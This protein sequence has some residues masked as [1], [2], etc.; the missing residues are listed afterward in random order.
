M[1]SGKINIEGIHIDSIVFWK[2]NP[3]IAYS[4]LPC[5]ATEKDLVNF[6]FSEQDAIHI[7]LSMT[8]SGFSPIEPLWGFRNYAGE[9]ECEGGRRIAAMKALLNPDMIEDSITRERLL[10][11][12]EDATV[13]ITGLVLVM[14][15]EHASMFTTGATNKFQKEMFG[16]ELVLL[17]SN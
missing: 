7:A 14:V 17:K 13:N 15:F 12:I 1:S 5:N 9:Y 8:V 16:G 4:S 6:Y 3:R 11:G 2:G 10:D